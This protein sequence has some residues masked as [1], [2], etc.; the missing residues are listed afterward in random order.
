MS[1]GSR[2][3]GHFGWYLRQFAEVV[4]R[5]LVDAL[6]RHRWQF[7]LILKLGQT[8]RFSAVVALSPGQPPILTIEP[9]TPALDAAHII[10]TQI[11]TKDFTVMFALVC[12]RFILGMLN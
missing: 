7:K 3:F 5:Q 8:Q 6:P 11:N 9:F 4:F 2:C 1:I 10:A 12:E